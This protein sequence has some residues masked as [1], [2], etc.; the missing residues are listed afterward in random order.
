MLVNHFLTIKLQLK[1]KIQVKDLKILYSLK[2]IMI[3]I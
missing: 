2:K 3:L 1:N